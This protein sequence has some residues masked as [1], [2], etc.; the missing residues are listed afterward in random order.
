MKGKLVILAG[1][2]SSRMKKSQPFDND[3][4]QRLIK[5]ADLKSKAMIRVGEN[6]RPFLDYLLFNAYESG[7]REI[8]IVIN[9]KDNSIK[10]YYE[11]RD[12]KKLFPELMISYVVQPIPDGRE[13]PLGTADALYHAL[14]LNSV[15]SDFSFTVC[16]SDNLYSQFAFKLLL[17]SEYK[18][19]MIDYNRNGL[20]FEKERIEKFSV[21]KKDDEGFLIDIIEKPT[22]NEIESSKDKSGAI[23]VSMNIFKLNYDMILPFLEI[24]PLHSVRKEKELPGAIKMM[25]EKFP[26][27][28]YAYPVSEEVPDLTG[29]EDILKVKMYLEKNFPKLS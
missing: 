9:E 8:V 7:Y 24:V 6:E 27:S 5:D 28:L 19:A 15:W 14:K 12:S 22:V 26:K 13:K 3:I 23:G 16:N 1:G 25:I 20:N 29:K 2:I 18:N 11:S 10:K 4:D 17:E 21:T